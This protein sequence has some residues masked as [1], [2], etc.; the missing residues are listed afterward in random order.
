MWIHQCEGIHNFVH[1]PVRVYLGVSMSVCTFMRAC[2][3]VFVCL[4]VHLSVCVYV[5]V[6]K[7]PCMIEVFCVWVLTYNHGRVPSGACG[8]AQTGLH[9]CVC[10]HLRGHTYVCKYFVEVCMQVCCCARA[11]V[12]VRVRAGTCVHVYMCVFG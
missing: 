8:S 10:P 5:H 2:V 1:V 9:V 4:C 11:C 3:C 6:F 7:C 12:C